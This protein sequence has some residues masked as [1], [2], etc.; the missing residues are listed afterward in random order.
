MWQA[1]ECLV[2]GRQY[3]WIMGT[4]QLLTGRACYGAVTT[5]E[6]MLPNCLIGVLAG[7]LG[8]VHAT[9]AAGAVTY[10]AKSRW[11]ATACNK[12]EGAHCLYST[13]M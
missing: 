8:D 13:H 11:L 6:W 12:R 3:P 2:W 5:N 10:S 9:C 7:S 1:G 4:L